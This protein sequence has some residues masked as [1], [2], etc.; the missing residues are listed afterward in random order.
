MPLHLHTLPHLLPSLSLPSLSLYFLSP[1]LHSLSRYFLSHSLLFLSLS[2]LL[3]LT[4]GWAPFSYSAPDRLRAA[5]LVMEAAV[6]DRGFYSAGGEGRGVEGGMGKEG[7]IGR[8][9]EGVQEWCV[10]VCSNEGR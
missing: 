10:C 6:I 2:P 1:S 3:T 4:I 7:K 5:G 8:V 9:G